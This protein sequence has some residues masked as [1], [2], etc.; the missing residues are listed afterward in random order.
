M[1][2][3]ATVLPERAGACMITQGMVQLPFVIPLGMQ[4]LKDK[5]INV[6]AIYPGY[7]STDMTA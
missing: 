1:R 4:E 6:T 3:H 2:M 5:N 7:V